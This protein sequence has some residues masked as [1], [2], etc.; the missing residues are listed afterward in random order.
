SATAHTA[1]A[2]RRCH[3]GSPTTT[4]EG[5]TARY[6]D[7]RQSAAFAT[8][9]GRTASL[10]PVADALT[11]LK[12]RFA[13]TTDLERMSRVLSWDQQTGIP[14]AGWRHR[15]EHL[16]TL[17]RIHHETLTAPETGRLLEEV[18]PLDPETDDGAFIRVA[19]RDYEKAS[20]VPTEL[21]AEMT[22]TATEARTI[23]VQARAQSDFELFR[24]AREE[25]Y[26][27]RR[28]YVDCCDEIE[29]YDVLL[30]DFEPETTTAEVTEV[31]AELKAELIPLIAEL[32]EQQVD[33]SFLTGNF[34]IDAQE[35]LAKEVVALFG[36]RS[37][38]WRLDPT[39]HPFAS[40]AG[41]DDIRIT[42]HYDPET[43]KSFFS[44]MHE[45][46]H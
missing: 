15:G 21:R 37:D 19:R 27:P 24:P 5:H 44:T 25:T 7:S 40:G 11:Q 14:P 3:T 9:V 32:R 10:R 18:P 1:N 31:F 35:R 38:T 4:R 30:D 17:R 39:E 46:G 45:Y 12:E 13:R 23:W 6:E 28:R 16:A 41:V 20:R 34:P 2:T 26:P 43:M 42:T 33:D 36:F 8:C 22:R 29:P